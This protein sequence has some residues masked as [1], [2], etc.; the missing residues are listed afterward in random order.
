MESST[1]EQVAKRWTPSPQTRFTGWVA[2]LTFALLTGL[3]KPRPSFA[4]TVQTTETPTANPPR[5]DRVPQGRIEGPYQWTSNIFPGTQRDYWIYVPAQ[6]D[7]NQPACLMVVQDGLSRARNW[8]LPTVMDNLIHHGEM[9]VTLGVFVSPGVVP[10]PHADAQ[11]RFNRSFEY[12]SL[13]DRYAR[14]LL[15]E[16]LPH[17]GRK[18]SLSEDP[19][20][21]AIAGASSGGICAFTVAWERP[22][23]FRRVLSTIGTY[24]GLRGGDS[25]PTLIRKTEP[26]P[27]RV[28]LQDGRNDLD[29]YGGDW[30]MANQSML[31]ALRFAKYDVHHAWGEGGHDP[32]HSRQIMPM[33]MRWLWRDYPEPIKANRDMSNRRT[34]LMV[35]GE[36]WQVV[37]EGHRFTEGPAV[38]D[39]GELFFSDIPAGKIFKVAA[40]GLVLEFVSDSPG[41]NGLMFHP[42]GHLYACQ[43]GKQRIV[44]YDTDGNESVVLEDAPCNDLVVLPQGIVYT[45]PTNHKLWFVNSQGQR[46]LLDDKL[47]FPNGVGVS[48][49]RTRLFVADTHDRFVYEYQLQGDGTVRYKQACGHLHLPDDTG[50]SEV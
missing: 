38:N 13:G 33:A 45:D 19:N 17:V 9:P 34:Q 42:D 32:N 2:I 40:D 43:N 39:A 23:S 47:K 24:V 6:Y 31:S 36:A 50:E 26:K 21:R 7:A 1:R 27:I 18:Y 22:D 25:Y 48:P 15:E 11:P 46:S 28:F 37:S 8:R 30:W 35:P 20:D 41:V 4:Q 29:I 5:Q 12:D 16:L 14:F 44:K 3:T 49:D 10:A